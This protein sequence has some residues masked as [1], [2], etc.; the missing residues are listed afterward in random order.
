MAMKPNK[1]S[2]FTLVE[3]M[4]ALIAGS[5]AV[6]G[7]YYL[8]G[9]SSRSFNEQMR[10]SETQLS[11]RSAMEQLRRDIGRA[12]FLAVPNS[13]TLAPNC[14]G[15]FGGSDVAPRQVRAV[16]ISYD[17]S[18][19]GSDSDVQ[20]V[21]ALLGTPDTNKTRA[22]ILRLWG[23]YA[24][25]D[26]YLTDPTRNSSSTIYFQADSESFRRSFYTPAA[27]NGTATY[28]DGA[29]GAFARAFAKGRMVRVEHEGR[30]FFRDIK[31]VKPALPT[32]Y[33]ELETPLPGCFEPTR[34]TAIAPVMR[35]RYQL[36][37][38]KVDDLKRLSAV[39]STLGARRPVLV[40]REEKDSDDSV[41]DDSARVVLDYAVEFAV[42]AIVNTAATLTDTPVWEYRTAANAATASASTERLRAL[43]VTLSSRSTE[44]DPNLPQ[45]GRTR[46]KT[47]NLLDSPLQTFRVIDPDKAE[48]VLNARVRTMRSEI[49]LQNL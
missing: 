2:G 41:V 36:E 15:S 18:I 34:W 32:P 33:V 31:D 37:H 3:L 9:I 8:S 11:L 29:T 20:K 14:G 48:I 7:T 49:F 24:T 40:R 43:V 35:V 45:L 17:G 28:E 44:A 27:N 39:S 21:K 13:A 6:A 25:S 4:I 38:D 30:Y 12:G 16:G 1:R 42:D 10:V 26:A 5:F 19:D 47:T 22:D 46:F 23:N